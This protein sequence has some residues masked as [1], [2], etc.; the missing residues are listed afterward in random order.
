MNSHFDIIYEIIEPFAREPFFTEDRH[1]AEHHYEEKRCSV[2]E[3]HITVTRLS[4]FTQTQQKITL[5]WHDEDASPE[6]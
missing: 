4:S 6:T 3:H 5:C 1:I 2:Y